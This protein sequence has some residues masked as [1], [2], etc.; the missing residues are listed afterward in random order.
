VQAP[1]TI[2][3]A[4]AS[5]GKGCPPD[6]EQQVAALFEAR[7]IAAKVVLVRDGAQILSEAEGAV[8]AGARCIVACGGDGTVSAVASKLVGSD[9][10]LGVLPMGTLNHFAK[11]A[12]IPLEFEGAID[13]IAKG[14]EARVDAAEVN[15]RI[16]INNSSLGLYPDIVLDR[17]RQRRRIGRGKWMA[18]AIASLNALR[19]YPVL[20]VVMDVDGKKLFRRSS[21]VFIG[22]NEYKMAGFEVGERPRLD[23]GQLALYV[24]QRTGRFGLLRLALRALLGRLDQARDFDSLPAASLRIET[25][26]RFLHVA[27]DGEV[28]VMRTPLE[29]RIRPGALRVMVAPSPAA[30][31]S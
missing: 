10:I 14:R 28:T 22:N 30:S 7:G 29:Y 13:V 17:E 21:F 27:T 11:D 25:R 4:N 3:I 18:L 23:T 31:Q 1:D 12:G 19:R 20:S 26:R 6:L 15:G 2:V 9:C 24:T 16:F 8:R 5:S